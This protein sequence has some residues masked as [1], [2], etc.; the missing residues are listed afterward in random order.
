MGGVQAMETFEKKF[1][2]NSVYQHNYG[3]VAKS[4]SPYCKYNDQ[5]Y[6]LVISSLYLAAAFAS[7][8]TEVLARKFGRRVSHPILN[9][10]AA[11]HP[12]VCSLC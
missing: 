12:F 3:G 11:Y 7:I 4:T 10:T 2:Y 5:I 6:Q 9:S 8:A 1:F